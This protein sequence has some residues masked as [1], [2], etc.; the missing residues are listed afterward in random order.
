MAKKARKSA[1]V[2]RCI[3]V[4]VTCPSRSVATR[5]AKTL[6]SR[7]LIACSN[8]I[9]EIESFFWWD[10]R[11]Q[12]TQEILLFLKTTNANQTRLL[13]AVR[14]LHPYDVPEVIALPIVAGHSPYLEWVAASVAPQ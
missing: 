13:E 14:S 4:M 1:R 2:P 7:R 10:G 9:P 8:I 6:V 3:V 5:L 12:R 11:V